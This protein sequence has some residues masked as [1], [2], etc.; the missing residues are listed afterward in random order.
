MEYKEQWVSMTPEQREGEYE[1]HTQSFYSVLETAETLS[2]MLNHYI[3]ILAFHK[4][5]D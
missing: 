5:Y 2:Y 4:S 1:T 3:S